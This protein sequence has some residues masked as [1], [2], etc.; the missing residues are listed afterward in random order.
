MRPML[1]CSL[2]LASTLAI[3]ADVAP[4]AAMQADAAQ[5]LVPVA[6]N[7]RGAGGEHFLTDLT[8]VNFRGVDQLVKLE[9]I[10]AGAPAAV[11]TTLV[12]P[13]LSYLTWSDVVGTQLHTEGLGAILVTAVDASGDPDAAGEIDGYARIW[14]AVSCEGIPGTVSQSLAPMLLGGWRDESPAYVH[15]VRHTSEFRTNWGVVNLDRTEA[16]R[17]QVIVNSG[18]GKVERTIE[19]EPFTMLQQP[20]PLGPYGD[21]SIYVEP[22]EPAGRW[23]AY[24][25]SVDNHTGSG[26]VVP[27]VQPRT[28]IVFPT[29]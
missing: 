10:P 20:V 28:D 15:G 18:T 27:A 5:F 16:R 17:F 8:V 7:V 21:L 24:A 4:T 19:L 2:L 3:A 22:L 25:S 12:V 26:W 29:Q 6:G 1:L 9:W 14:T 13:F 11:E 23:T